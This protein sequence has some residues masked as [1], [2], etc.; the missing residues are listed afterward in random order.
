[1][2]IFYYLSGIL[3]DDDVLP[4][5]GQAVKELLVS[6]V[7]AI[8]PPLCLTDEPQV[9]LGAQAQEILQIGNGMQWGA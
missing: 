2:Q 4:P 7:G 8:G 9:L 1:M 6:K 5:D 3:G